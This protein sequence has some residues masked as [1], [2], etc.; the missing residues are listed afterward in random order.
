MTFDVFQLEVKMLKGMHAMSALNSSKL[1][2]IERKKSSEKIVGKFIVD[3]RSLIK[4]TNNRLRFLSAD[5][6]CGI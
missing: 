3:R 4:L 5:S 1:R 2:E 6:L